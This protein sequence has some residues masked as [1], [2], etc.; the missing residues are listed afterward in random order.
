MYEYPKEDLYTYSLMV[1]KELTKRGYHI[2]NFDNF[3]EY[4]GIG[5]GSGNTLNTVDTPFKNHH[6]LEYLEICYYN[7][8]EKYIRK[9][10][11]FDYKTFVML[12]NYVE[13][14]LIL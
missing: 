3:Y 6:N 2:T 8:K 13:G 12:K 4:F 14:A 7:L 5:F 10:V 11:G 1:I 9:Q